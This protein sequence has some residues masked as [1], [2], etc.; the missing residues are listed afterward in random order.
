MAYQLENLLGEFFAGEEFA[1][2]TGT[3]SHCL[4]LS[5]IADAAAN[6]LT[7]SQSEHA[8]HC[9]RCLHALA[10][11]FGDECPGGSLLAAYAAGR[12]PIAEAVRQHIDQDDCASCR[13]ALSEISR[14]AAAPTPEGPEQTL[15]EECA[16]WRSRYLKAIH[17]LTA[18]GISGV[19]S[20]LAGAAA[21]VEVTVDAAHGVARILSEPA[22]ACRDPLAPMGLAYPAGIA[23][24]SGG[25]TSKTGTQS[26][27]L[28]SGADL[29]TVRIAAD[30]ERQQIKMQFMG[31]TPPPVVLLI[32]MD[33]ALPVTIR[34]PEP[35]GPIHQ[36][37][38]SDVPAGE[39]L[40][41]LPRDKKSE[42]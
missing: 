13:T 7:P 8:A 29:P 20:L 22:E 15:S 25:D 35:A 1:R 3:T 16:R 24:R 23:Y 40:I 31:G 6:G 26:S 30:A 10:L 33:E 38:F 2:V 18:K 32:P 9:H 4:S 36:V 11:A 14:I 28:L 42:K 34:R 19:E 21:A 41:A 39:C 5:V 17:D 12:L 27:A 37:L